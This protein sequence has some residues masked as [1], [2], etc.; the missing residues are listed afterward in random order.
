MSETPRTDVGVDYWINT[1]ELTELR[2]I[3]EEMEHELFRAN[4]LIKDCLA[5]MPVGYIPTHT[6]ENL[7]SMIADLARELAEETQNSEKLLFKTLFYSIFL[8]LSTFFHNILIFLLTLYYIWYIFS[9]YE[10]NAYVF[11][12]GAPAGSSIE[13]RSSYYPSRCD[14]LSQFR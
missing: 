14:I 5:A 13:Y 6:R 7:P 3:S 12:G 11:V 2:D 10:E 9:P 8:D 1:G 4:N